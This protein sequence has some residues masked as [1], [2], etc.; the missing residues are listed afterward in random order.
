[1]THQ[2]TPPKTA[3]ELLT[4]SQAAAR[5]GLKETTLAQMRCRGDGP[6]FHKISK[7]VRYDS[8]DLERWMRSRRYTSTSEV[9][10]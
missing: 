9:A 5:T 3:G 7:F 1:M 4:P 10:A 2:A 6:I 8:A